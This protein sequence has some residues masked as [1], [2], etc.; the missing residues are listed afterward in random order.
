MSLW[1][2]GHEPSESR[3]LRQA[4]S[5]VAVGCSAGITAL[6]AALSALR[7]IARVPFLA[8]QR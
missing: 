4:L 8:L 3:L 1:A 7:S 2:G 6:A 5:Q